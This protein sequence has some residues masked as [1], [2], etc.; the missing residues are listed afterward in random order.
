[1]LAA[2]DMTGR[3]R[4]DFFRAAVDVQAGA[5]GVVTNDGTQLRA[6]AD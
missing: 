5:A 6:R 2:F 1:V 4:L 3:W